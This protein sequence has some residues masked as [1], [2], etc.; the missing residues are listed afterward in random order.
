[1]I[2]LIFYVLVS[3]NILWNYIKTISQLLFDNKLIIYLL[4]QNA[5]LLGDGFRS[6]QTVRFLREMR[7]EKE[8]TE[9]QKSDKCNHNQ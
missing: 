9:H 5:N 3:K 2:E 6:E 8:N 4:N 1:M 7:I